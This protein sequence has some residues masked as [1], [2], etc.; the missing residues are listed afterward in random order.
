LC[1]N[2]PQRWQELALGQ[3]ACPALSSPLLV[4]LSKGE[5]A[6]ITTRK[7]CSHIDVTKLKS[8]D[9]SSSRFMQVLRKVII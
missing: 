5:T 3:A 6:S 9:T 4:Q 2:F 8:L 7:A 1:R